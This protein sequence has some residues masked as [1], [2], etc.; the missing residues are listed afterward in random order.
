MTRILQ[1]GE[2]EALDRIEFPRVRL[3]QPASLFVDRAARLRQRA[4]GHPIGD[5]LRFLA[6]VADQQARQAASVQTVLPA[7]SQ[8]ERALLHAMPV[9]PA[10]LQPDTQWQ[11]V[12]MALM[13]GLRAAAGSDGLVPAVAEQ[14]DQLAALSAAERGS[15]ATACLNGTVAAAQLGLQPLVMAALQVVYADVASRLD[16]RR[17]A[18]V[19]PATVCPVCGGAPVASVLR[20]GGEAGGHRYLHCGLCATEWHMVR[21]KC[22]HCESTRGVRYQGIEDGDPAVLAET[23]DTCH[24]YRK[25]VN[26]EK[27]PL[28]EPLADDLASLMLDLL[29]AETAYTRA[30]GNPLLA[31]AADSDEPEA[32]A[33]RDA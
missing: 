28:A 24:T 33:A 7:E 4:E 12:L 17:I 20:I 14:L 18:F 23:C 19:E 32:G 13:D 31:L 9:L 8:I 22:S 6:Q 25:Q 27:D 29:M 1:P 11:P 5:Y 10:P 16:A 2:I 3:P 15:L 21:V 26:Q 30:S